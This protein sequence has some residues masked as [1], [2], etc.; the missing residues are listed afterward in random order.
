MALKE[1]IRDVFVD[2]KESFKSNGILGVS[3]Y[4]LIGKKHMQRWKEL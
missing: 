2:I 3:A 4:L 1:F